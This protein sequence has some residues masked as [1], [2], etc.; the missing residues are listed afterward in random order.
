MFRIMRKHAHTH[1]GTHTHT[2]THSEGQTHTHT[3]VR[4][5]GVLRVPSTDHYRTCFTVMPQ[6]CMCYLRRQKPSHNITP[7][8]VHL[9]PHRGY[10]THIHTNHLLLDTYKHTYI[11][12]SLSFIHA[13]IFLS[14]SSLKHKVMVK[15][16]HTHTLSLFLSHTHTHTH[17]ESHI[18]S[19]TN[20]QRIIYCHTHTQNRSLFCTDTLTQT[21]T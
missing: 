4:K 12:F 15:H 8:F 3:T 6:V 20:A 10:H 18:L 21:H 13:C 17:T 9:T 19:H 14:W 16:T 7:E 11:I 2:H 1:T 5:L